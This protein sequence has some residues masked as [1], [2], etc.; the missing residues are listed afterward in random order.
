MCVGTPTCAHNHRC[1]WSQRET[2]GLIPLRQ[3]ILLNLELAGR[4][5]PTISLLLWT[6]VADTHDYAS[7]NVAFGDLNELRSSASTRTG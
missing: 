3:G 2:V 6:G 1:S 4:Q 5:R 7:L